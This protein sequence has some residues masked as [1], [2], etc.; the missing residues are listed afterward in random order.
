MVSSLTVVAMN[1]Y[2]LTSSAPSSQS[3]LTCKFEIWLVKIYKILIISI[4][5]YQVLLQ[6][7][8]LLLVSLQIMSEARQTRRAPSLHQ[9]ETPIK[10]N[11]AEASNE[12][13]LDTLNLKRNESV[14]RNDA[15][16]KEG[17]KG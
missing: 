8:Q 7:V 17:K 1:S 13:N 5:S 2:C 11:S 3:D 9:W 15:R 10:A 12:S 4:L 16:D 6:G 14:K